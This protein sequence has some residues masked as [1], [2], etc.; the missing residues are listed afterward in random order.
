MTPRR[1]I[2]G[3][4]LV[5]Y[6]LFGLLGLAV[7]APNTFPGADLAVFQQAGHDLLTRGNPYASNATAHYNF[8]YRYPPLLAMFIPVLGWPP[9]WYVLLAAST[10]AVFYFWWR[11]AGWFGLAPIIMLAGPWGQPLING[12]V[13]PVLMLF[14]ALVPRFRRAGAIAL[15][16]AT[17][18]K[19]HP[20]LGAVW[21]VGRRD[22]QGLTWYAGAMVVLLVIQAPWLGLFI[23]YYQTDA[24]ASITLY[25]GWGLRLAGDVA[26]IVGAAITGLLALRFAP[27]RYGWMLN[28]IFQLAALP[29]L[30]P[31]NLA[32]LLSAPLPT[33]RSRQRET[34][35][36][37]TESE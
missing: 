10:A 25:H 20:A 19:L 33:R 30:L 15:A 37:A 27:S 6:A 21:Y 9:L 7:L 1:I 14:L 35:T 2:L 4:I 28:V 36:V 32:L 11:D 23:D 22:W 18:L 17:M 13:Q 3:I 24:D 8:Q 31:T 26:W 16:V 5:F 34:Q 29:R 12:N